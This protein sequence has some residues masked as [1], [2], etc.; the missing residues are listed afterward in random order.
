VIFTSDNGG[1]LNEG[2]K[3]A[4][5]A[6]HRL[7]GDLLGFKF[8]AWEGGHRV[9]FIARWP[10]KIPAGSE[11]SQLIANVDLLRTVAEMLEVDLPSGTGRDSL[12]V[13]PALLGEPTEPLRDSVVLAPHLRANLALRSG[14]WVYIGAQGSGGFGNGLGEIA[15]AGHVNSD[16]DPKGKLR[17]NAPQ[18][19]L[20]HL[21]HDPRQQRNVIG[22]HPEVAARLKAQLEKLRAESPPPAKPAKGKA[23]GKKAAK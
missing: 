10:G 4:W 17:P 20:Y 2:G 1:M 13:L 11:S 14:P 21:E 19:Q 12:A 3:Q 5:T 7:N 6:G 23:T 15:F 16:V 22:D 9:P 18:E 8:G